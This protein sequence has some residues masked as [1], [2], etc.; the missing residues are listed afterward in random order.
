[1]EATLAVAKVV[2]MHAADL[3]RAL[4]DRAKKYARV[5]S[6]PHCFSYGDE[7]AVCFF[8]YDGDSRHG[9]FL[10]RSYKAI[11]ANPDWKKR[12][13]KVHT[14]GKR[15]LPKTERGRWMELD[16]CASSD[17][18]LMNVFCHPAALRSG[19]VPILLDVN[20]DST[21]VF[22]YRAR[23]PLAN[24]R[25]DRTEIDMR[26]GDLLIEAKLTESDFQTAEKKT[27]LGYRDFAEVFDWE[28]LPQTERRYSSYQLLRNVLAAF[29]LRCSFCV[30]IDA[31]RADLAE[32]WYAVMKCVKPVELR[33][34]L[35]VCT[36]QELAGATT[37]RIRR[38]LQAKYGIEC[39]G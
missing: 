35:R 25:F 19:Q 10:D 24:G 12:L 1:V 5:E 32:A 4:A 38:F 21:R 36:W 3:R 14:L 27:L 13:A 28:E 7:P 16:T 29:A 20:V 31:R 17:A 6:I 11:R 37:P 30:L 15:S 34:N 18:L 26:L 23:V 22:G 2:L 9:N 33:T 8:P 39:A